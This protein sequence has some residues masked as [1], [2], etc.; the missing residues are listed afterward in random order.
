M[1]QHVWVDLEG[2][3]GLD[4]CTLDKLYREIDGMFFRA[5][6][7][8]YSLEDSDYIRETPVQLDRS[9]VAGR[10]LSR[11]PGLKSIPD[12]KAQCA[13]VSVYP[14]IWSFGDFRT[15]IARHNAAGGC[16]NQYSCTRRA[17]K[18]FPLLTNKS[19]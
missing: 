16:I 11:Q 17:S 7:Y 4:A 6:T 10:A 19:S 1:T 13:E 9:S 3:L 2:Q 18:S 14:Q 15:A 5:A 12:I 8:G